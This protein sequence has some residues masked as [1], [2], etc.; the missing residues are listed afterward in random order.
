LFLILIDILRGCPHAAQ[1]ENAISGGYITCHGS[2]REHIPGRRGP[3]GFLKTL[4]A[5]CQKTGFEIHAYRLM[6]KQNSAML[7]KTVISWDKQPQPIK[8]KTKR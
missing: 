5:T 2:G 7:L 4:A 8:Q 6:P 1:I 3:T